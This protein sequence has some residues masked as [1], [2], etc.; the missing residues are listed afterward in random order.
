MVFENTP[1]HQPIENNEGAIYDVELEITLK[2]MEKD[3]TGLF[4]T[5]H[6]PQRGWMLKN[7]P[8]KMLRGTEVEINDNKDNITPG[9]QKVFT[10]KTYKTAKSMN[11]RDKVVFR[12]SLQETGYY[13]R[14]PSKGRMAGRDKY[15][16][17]NL[18]DDISRILNLDNK[19]KGRGV[20][21][22]IIPSNIIHIYTRLE[23]LLGLKLSGHTDTL[24]EAS[25]L[26]DEL[27]KRGEIQ[28]KREY[29]NALAK[30][31]T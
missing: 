24:T 22:I 31:Q 23:V 12:A 26:I 18:D 29:R 13:N 16:Q 30:F 19:F 7:Y 21:K 15:I 17:S 6:D 8:I 14:L 28:N 5:Y 25:N 2:N 10:D 9:L 3:N 27:Y 20:E 4:K 1:P 11:D